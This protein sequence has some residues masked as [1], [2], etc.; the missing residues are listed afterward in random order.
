MLQT[1]MDVAKHHGH[2]FMASFLGGLASVAFAAW[3]SVTLVAVYV[4]YEPA[5]GGS[6]NPSC[7]TSG[8]SSAT[9]IGLIVFI[10]FAGYWITEW[11]KN[12]LHT[13]IA[14]VYG[15]WYFCSSKPAGCP[16][17]RPGGPSDAQ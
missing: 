16:P 9:V 11:M 12:T 15:S 4:K 6:S 13:T 14:G 2:V 10:T 17:A 7:G 5:F 3:F 8:C 1:C